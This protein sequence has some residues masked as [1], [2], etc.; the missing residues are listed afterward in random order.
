MSNSDILL[1][2]TKKTSNFLKSLANNNRLIIV[3]TLANGEHN[4]SQLEE[5]LDIRQPTLSQQLARLRADD[6]VAT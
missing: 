1:E 2:N 4:V 6:L 5:A 3:C